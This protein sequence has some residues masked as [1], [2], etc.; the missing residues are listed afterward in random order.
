MTAP[1]TRKLQ[2]CESIAS[3]NVREKLLSNNVH[4]KNNVL[5]MFVFRIAL[6]AFPIFHVSDEIII[7]LSGSGSYSK[8]RIGYSEILGKNVAVKQIDLRQQNEYIRR[9][10]P[11]ELQIIEKLKHPNVVEVYQVGAPF[12]IHSL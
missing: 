1:D 3:I 7:Y 9:F 11:R 4:L 2:G 5:G 8:V 10:L 12:P 6:R